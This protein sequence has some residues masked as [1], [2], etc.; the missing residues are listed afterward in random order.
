M[1]PA[2]IAAALATAVSWAACAMFFTSASRRIGSFSMN[3]WRVLFG[4]ALLLLIHAAVTGSL[5]PDA[6]SRQWTL[7]LASGAVGVFVGD[8]FLFQSY[9]D[10]GPRQGLLIFNANPFFTAM[11]AWP[12]LG[13]KLGAIAW[14]GMA[15]TVGG[16]LWVLSEENPDGGGRPRYHTRGVIFALLAALC[17]STGYVVAKP[18]ITGEGGLDPLAA[19]LVRV[20]AAVFLFWG[21]SFLRGEMPRIVRDFRHRGAMLLIFGGA[22]TGPAIG[23]WLSLTALKLIPAGIAATLMATMPVVILPFVVFFYKERVSWRA[24]VGAAVAIAGVAIL[25]NA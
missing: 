5:L 18:A 13:E 6:T 23:I 8:L 20:G 3:N 7:L 24:A 17:Q 4:T 12:L 1:N 21:T 2:G 9:I 19:S 11:I 15:V 22:I 16:T 14:L 10:I 25:A